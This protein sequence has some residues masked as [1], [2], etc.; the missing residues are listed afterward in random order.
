MQGMSH[1]GYL[2]IPVQR[3]VLFPA[4]D[5]YVYS[6]GAIS[7]IDPFYRIKDF[8]GIKFYYKHS[9]HMSLFDGGLS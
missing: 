5:G 3:L 4:H 1:G 7:H 8:W 9:S 6:K 2:L